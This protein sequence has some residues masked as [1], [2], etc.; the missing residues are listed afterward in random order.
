MFQEQIGAGVWSET[1]PHLH[2]KLN[3]VLSDVHP[4]SAFEDTNSLMDGI[5]SWS[6]K[7]NV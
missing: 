7:G 4:N 5:L 3:Y 1:K 2:N 6:T